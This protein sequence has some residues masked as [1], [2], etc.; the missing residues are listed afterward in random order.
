MAFRGHW[1]WC[2]GLKRHHDVSDVYDCFRTGVYFSDQTGDRRRNLNSRLVSLNFHQR[3]VFADHLPCD[4]VHANDL[5]LVD[6]LAKIWKF[7][8]VHGGCHRTHDQSINSFAAA[9]MSSGSGRKCCST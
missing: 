3:I 2:V 5:A 4:D 7:E 8:L 9:M 1:C 6:A